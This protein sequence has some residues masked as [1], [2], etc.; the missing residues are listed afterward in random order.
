VVPS[1]IIFKDIQ[2]NQTYEITVYIRNLTKT[3]RRIRVYQPQTPKFRADYDMQGAIAAGIA[4]KLVITFETSV[5]DKNGFHD[6]LKIVSDENYERDIPLH[7]YPQQA[8]ILFEP[9][10][11]LGFVKMNSQKTEKIYFLN[12]GKI[13]AKVTLKTADN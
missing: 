6:T 5:I 13:P 3:S 2:T 11:N 12:E 8:S 7:A 10:L 1:E 9:F 4:M